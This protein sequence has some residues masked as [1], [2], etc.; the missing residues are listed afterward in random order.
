MLLVLVRAIFVL[1]IAGFGVQLAYIVRDNQLAN[2]IVV[3]IGIMLLTVMVVALDLVTRRKRIQTI[4]AIYIGF[5]VGIFL[6]NLLSSALQPTM[7][8]YLKPSVHNIFLT[9]LYCFVCYICIST[10]LQTKDDFR[11]IIPYVEFSKEVKGAATT[12]ARYVGRDRRAN[13]RCRRDP[14]DRSADDHSSVCA[15]GA[16]EHSG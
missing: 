7:Q 8:L 4:S 13:R 1:V 10:L 9:F 3:F 15:S 11:F 14:G 16:S 12:G 6:T 2:P 5:I